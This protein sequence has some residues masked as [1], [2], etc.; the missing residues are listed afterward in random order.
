MSIGAVGRLRARSQERRDDYAF[1]P[2]DHFWFRP[3]YTEGKC[4]LCGAAAIGGAPPPPLW[5]RTDRP[6]LGV[7]ALT[8]ESLGMLALVL[9]MYFR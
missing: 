6:W 7:T 3:S 8:L 9:F 5:R 2:H 1:C 4:P